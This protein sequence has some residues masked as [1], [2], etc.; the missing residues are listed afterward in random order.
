MTS[1]VKGPGGPGG[2]VQPPIDT[3][4]RAQGSTKSSFREALSEA[5]A[6][7]A[8]AAAP[9]DPVARALADGTIDPAGAV[10]ALV[11]RAIENGRAQGLTPAGIE[12]LRVHLLTALENDPALAA[13]V[14]DLESS[15]A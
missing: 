9:M 6:S 3:P 8:G 11:E 13:L 15:K 5:R 14:R 4:D 2:I 12:A 7:A 1:S 10:N